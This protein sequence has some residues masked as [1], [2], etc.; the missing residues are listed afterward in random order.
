MFVVHPVASQRML[1]HR[2]KRHWVEGAGRKR[3]PDR[4]EA[5]SLLRSVAS[6]EQARAG[7]AG[8]DS[9]TSELW[10]TAADARG[11]Q[12]HSYGQARAALR[13]EG[14]P[15][16]LCFG[17]GWGLAPELTQAADVRLEPIRPPGGGGYNH[18]SVRAACAITLDRLFAE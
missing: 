13:A 16:L 2:I 18:L 9:Q 15:V 7:L 5:L 17:T 1:V 4:A 14:P 10:T 3:I 8:P 11:A 6:V 12:V